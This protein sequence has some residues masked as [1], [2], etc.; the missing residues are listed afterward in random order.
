MLEKICQKIT[1]YLRTRIKSIDD[2]KA[3]V[4]NFGLLVILGEGPKLIIII[5][6]AWWLDILFLTLVTL[7]A[8]SLYRTQSGGFHLEGHISCFVVSALIFCGTGLLA[9][10]MCNLPVSVQYFTYGLMFIFNI[11]IIDKYAPADTQNIPILNEKIRKKRKDGSYIAVTALF[12][13]A[14]ICPDKVISNICVL[15]TFIQSLSMTQTAYKLAKC[16]YG[17]VSKHNLGLV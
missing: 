9:Q 14:I 12:L 3:E 7:I 4:I 15:V 5:L 10:A 17:D 6:L 1:N 16:E 8:M 2:E 11:I 13:F